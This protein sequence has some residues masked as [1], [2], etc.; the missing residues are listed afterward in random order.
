MKNSLCH[1]FKVKTFAAAA[2]LAAFGMQSCQDENLVGQPTWLN[3]SIYGWLQEQGNYEYTLR[4]INDLNMAS[5][6]NQTGSK[7]LF[8]ADDAAFEAFF[9]ENGWNVK[10]YGQLSVAQKKMLLNSSMVNNAYLIELL[11]NVPGNPPQEGMCMRREVALSVYDSVARIMP[12]D[13]P[14]TKYWN[15][16]RGRKDGVLLMRDN[17][18]APMIHLLPRFMKTNN[19]TDG[20]LAKLTNGK[21][22]GR[23]V[24]ER[25]KGVGS[26]GHH[27]QERLRAK[28]GGSN[29]AGR[30]H[31]GNHP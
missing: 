2:L 10:N 5:V 7:T 13:M 21:S 16:V 25:H 29:H 31:G 1:R 19:I 14:Q 26:H 12:E 4:L 30:Q 11:S 24:G 23:V 17:S 3:N 28:G 27:V 6:L 8:A 9:K 18:S 15:K 20:D 22:C